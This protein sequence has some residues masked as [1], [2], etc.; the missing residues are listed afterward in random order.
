MVEE[1]GTRGGAEGTE[2]TLIRTLNAILASYTPV[3]MTLTEWRTYSELAEL[4][5]TV[6]DCQ[7]TLVHYLLPF[8]AQLSQRKSMDLLTFG[9]TFLELRAGLV[10]EVFM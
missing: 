7:I 3:R 8:N 4:D 9:E 1:E 10:L 5:F 6:F 2:K